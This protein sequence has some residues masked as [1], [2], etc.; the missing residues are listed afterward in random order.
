MKIVVDTHTLFW[1]I[2]GD[3]RLSLSA[4]NTF[5]SAEQIFTPT[6]VLLELFSLMK[7]KKLLDTF[8]RSLD[9]AKNDKRFVFVSLD[10]GSVESITAD[11]LDLELHDAVIVATS[12][13]FNTP[14]LTKDRKIKKVYKNTIW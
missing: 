3:K 6:I 9:T 1:F 8:Y 12:K 10:M 11:L 7:K 5:E 4:K 13:L 2:T 14:I